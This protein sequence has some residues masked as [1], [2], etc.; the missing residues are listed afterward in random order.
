MKNKELTYCAGGLVWR[1]GAVG[2]ELLLIRMQEWQS[3]MLPKGRV[4][5]TDAGW[6]AAALRE[7][8]E[9]TGYTSVITDFAGH[10]QYINSRGQEKLVFFWHM[11]PD[12]E[13]SFAPNNEIDACEWVP[14]RAAI[15]QLTTEREQNFLRQFAHEHEL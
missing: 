14:L 1:D 11:A 15:A 4:E 9:E 13:S 10:L 2:R 3:W 6:D 12:G 8:K 7:V 5:P